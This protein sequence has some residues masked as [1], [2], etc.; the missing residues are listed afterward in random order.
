VDILDRRTLEPGLVSDRV[1]FQV[2]MDYLYSLSSST[3]LERQ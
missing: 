1:M 2:N 3:K